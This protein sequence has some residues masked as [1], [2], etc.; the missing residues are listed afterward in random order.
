[1]RSFDSIPLT[2]CRDLD[3]VVASPKSIGDGADDA[4]KPTHEDVKQ[5]LGATFMVPFE[6]NR[7]SNFAIPITKDWLA[8]GGC[9]DKDTPQREIYCQ[10]DVHVCAD[11]GEWNRIVFFHGFGDL[12]MIFGLVARN[13]GFSLGTKGLKVGHLGERICLGSH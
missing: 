3:F 10:V 9:L 8:Q 13:C 11:E 6:A 12:G 4:G 2:G 7:T 1:M 5:A